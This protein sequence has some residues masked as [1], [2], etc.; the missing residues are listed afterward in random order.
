MLTQSKIAEIAAKLESLP[1]LPKSERRHTNREAV[2]ILKPIIEKMKKK[3][4]TLSQ[5]ANELSNSEL[6]VSESSLRSYLSAKKA[7][8]SRKKSTALNQVS[9]S[10]ETSVISKSEPSASGSGAFNVKPDRE[11]L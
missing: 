5:I 1:E 10:L 6:K 9:K 7:L 11:T 4:Y 3:G 8:T 2:L